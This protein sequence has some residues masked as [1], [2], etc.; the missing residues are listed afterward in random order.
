MWWLVWYLVQALDTDPAEVEKTGNAIFRNGDC[1]RV[2]VTVFNGKL[3]WKRAI[4]EW[5]TETASLA[6][7]SLSIA[8]LLNNGVFPASVYESF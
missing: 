1:G 8:C 3:L 6:I 5:H 4:P 7:T 2:S